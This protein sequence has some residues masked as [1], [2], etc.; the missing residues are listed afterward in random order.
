MSEFTYEVPDNNAF[1]KTVLMVV[2]QNA[3]IEKASIA[4]FDI[5]NV[6]KDGYCEIAPS[7]SFSQKRW[8]AMHTTI[9]FYVLPT[10]FQKCFANSNYIKDKLKNICQSVIPANAGYDVMNIEISPILETEKTDFNKIVEAI[11]FENLN[12]LTE[13]IKN[14][15]R[16]MAEVY[17]MLY[18]IENSLRNFIDVTFTY[19]FGEKYMDLIIIPTKLKNGIKI[20]TNEEK[21]N[22]WLSLRGDK[23]VYY[24]DFVDLSTL[25][26]N[27]WESFKTIFSNQAWISTKINELYSIR[28]LIAHNSFVGNDERSLI[29][30]N[31]KQI[32]KQ[33]AQNAV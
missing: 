18:C 23:D 9:Y 24:L 17:T 19:Q 14:K 12:I 8:D 7:N 6:I 3:T 2:E 5:Y 27:N 25:I 33:I 1:F 16:E 32:I 21:Q 31:Y 20:R 15:G 11:N 30:M 13:E 29:V 26:T 10:V 28:C 4:F 22:K